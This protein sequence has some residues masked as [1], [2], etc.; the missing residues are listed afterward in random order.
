MWGGANR[1]QNGEQ[2]ALDR[3]RPGS[4]RSEAEGY[5]RTN[6]NSLS[7]SSSSYSLSPSSPMGDFPSGV[8]G[9]RPGNLGLPSPG[10]GLIP[11]PI[12]SPDQQNKRHGLKISFSQPNLRQKAK[13]G[14]NLQF[15]ATGYEAQPEKF[16]IYSKVQSTGKLKFE[17]CEHNFCAEDLV[18]CGEIGRGNFGAVNKMMFRKAGRVMAVKRI[19]YKTKKES[20]S[21]Q[22]L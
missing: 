18:D 3:S 15:P 4:G 14:M 20:L 8:R 7:S 13:G 11:G 12:T 5:L 16:L 21:I 1:P 9:G 22:F 2:T 10:G 17:D 6:Q 19:R